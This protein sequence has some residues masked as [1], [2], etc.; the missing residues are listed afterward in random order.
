MAGAMSSDK[1]VFV[2]FWCSYFKNTRQVEGF[3]E[4]SR[5][6]VENGWTYY[7]VLSKKP[8]DDIWLSL[9]AAANLQII[10]FKRPEA[11]LDVACI[12]NVFKLC[13]ALNADIIHCAN[14]HTSPLIGAFLAGVPVRLWYKVSMNTA[15]EECRKLTLHDRLALTTRI[16]C[17]A[18]TT[19]L[20]I[21]SSVKKELV[22]LGIPDG[23]VLVHYNPKKDTS[24]VSVNRADA[25]KYFGYS[26]SDVVALTVGHAVPV[27]GWDV[28]IKAYCAIVSRVPDLRIL[29]VGSTGGG[30]EKETYAALKA[31][32]NRS[33]IA[34]AVRFTGYIE[35]AQMLETAYRCA[36]FFVLPSRSEGSAYVLIEAMA[37]G[38]PCIATRVG[39]AE[40]LIQ[41]TVNG[42][43]VDR[44]DPE[45]LSQALLSLADDTDRRKRFASMVRIP[46][47]IPTY[48]E[49]RL[50]MVRLCDF[51]LGQKSRVP[52]AATINTGRGSTMPRSRSLVVKSIAAAAIVLIC[53]GF[54]MVSFTPY[55]F[56]AVGI[57]SGRT[58]LKLTPFSG[59]SGPVLQASDI[60]DIPATGVAD[61]FLVRT[62]DSLY[63]FVE[64]VT[65]DRKTGALGVATSRDGVSWKYRKKIL[66]ENFH[67][68]YP[69]V[70]AVHDRYYL[71]PESSEAHGIR[72]YSSIQFPLKWKFEK[73]LLH[74]DFV[75][76]SVCYFND[77]FWLFAFNLNDKSLYLYFSDSIGGP[78]T[79][80]PMN[81][82][83]KNNMNIARPGG[84]VLIVHDTILRF[85]Q[86]DSPVYGN[87]SRVM[88]VDRLMET[89]YAEHEC[90][91]S[92]VLTGSGTGWNSDGMHTV[93]PVRWNDSVWIASVD[94][95]QFRKK[96]DPPRGFDYLKCAIKKKYFHANVK[97]DDD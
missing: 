87:S 39:S 50:K 55:A 95:K 70:F 30:N 92:P 19:V 12:F 34:E 2:D 67:L 68:S 46:G 89:S 6:F 48:D 33:G 3:I 28:L 57:Y 83:V 35:N 29:L 15:F 23:K 40:E 44:N 9:C 26:D 16:S 38:L 74:G 72:L 93:D 36:D 24:G 4:S 78:W 25:R 5:S 75:D 10:Y 8:D 64:I 77:K 90:A 59:T 81:P 80:H 62:D 14:I 27:K 45:Q 96:F 47:I 22:A 21:S 61:P 18:C 13:R 60:T 58:P 1:K 51:L 52:S 71:I 41:D 84:R 17:F 56:W 73:E 53:V 82:V 76:N 11:H 37:A 65:K 43:L 79:G 94:G 85:V 97:N 63:L 20:A 31:M 7:L 54:F 88:M 91:E 49:Y 86:D 69:Y 66:Q 32:V 42:I